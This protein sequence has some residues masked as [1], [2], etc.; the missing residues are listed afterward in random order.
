LQVFPRISLIIAVPHGRQRR[1]LG[2]KPG[3]RFVL[4]LIGNGQLRRGLRDIRVAEPPLN[5]V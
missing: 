4:S 2:V 1:P 3:H 5:D